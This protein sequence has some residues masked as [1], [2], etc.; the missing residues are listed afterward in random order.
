MDIPNRPKIFLYLN[1]RIQT[2]L[3]VWL[4]MDFRPVHGSMDRLGRMVDRD[5]TLC[6]GIPVSF[7]VWKP[8]PIKSKIAIRSLSVLAW[9]VSFTQSSIPRAILEIFSGHM[10]SKNFS[11]KRDLKKKIEFFSF[12][13]DLKI[14]INFS[15]FLLAM[16]HFLINY[17]SLW[18]SKGKI[19]NEIIKIRGRLFYEK[20][21][22]LVGT[23]WRKS[24][25]S[26]Q[27][28]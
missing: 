20:N 13:L 23:S 8:V 1:H 5:Q 7:R 4:S 17:S 25:I 11:Q 19:N 26:C 18:I 15:L 28:K 16:I 10:I 24:E 12:Y 27:V 6:P 22:N 2:D 3:N 21:V 9:R 14:S